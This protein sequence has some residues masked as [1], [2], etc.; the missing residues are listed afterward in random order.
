MAWTV[1]HIAHHFQMDLDSSFKA[2]TPKSSSW[3]M[4][5]EERSVLREGTQLELS[6]LI[7]L[8]DLPT[9][10]TSQPEVSSLQDMHSTSYRSISRLAA[11]IVPSQ[12]WSTRSSCHYFTFPPLEFQRFVSQQSQRSNQ[13]SSDGTSNW[14]T[15][16]RW[17]LFEPLFWLHALHASKSSATSGSK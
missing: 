10:G 9:S 6:S 5:R 7:K 13:G 17:Y 1:D 4:R 14:Q 15:N 16:A 3:N 8:T 11:D 12:R 2:H